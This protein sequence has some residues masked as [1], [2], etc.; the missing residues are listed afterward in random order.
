MQKLAKHKNA[1]KEC[2]EY[3][4][5]RKE[6]ME[7]EKTEVARANYKYDLSIVAE[8]K[9]H[10]AELWSIE[11]RAQCQIEDLRDEMFYAALGD[12]MKLAQ[13]SQAVDDDQ[14]TEM[15]ADVEDHQEDDQKTELGGTNSP[16]F[17]DEEGGLPENPNITKRLPT[18]ES[19]RGF[20]AEALRDP[21]GTISWER[22]QNLWPDFT[23]K[24][25]LSSMIQFQRNRDQL[26]S[27]DPADDEQARRG[28]GMILRAAD[29]LR[30][31]E[32]RRVQGPWCPGSV[33]GG[34]SRQSADARASAPTQQGR[35]LLPAQGGF[36]LP[37]PFAMAGG[38]QLPPLGNLRQ[39]HPPGPG[40]PGVFPPR[41]F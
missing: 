17:S 41:P 40:G 2:P 31:S 35:R 14:H 12:W 26:D 25:R 11:H 10:E 8:Q 36:G 30:E 27:R 3:D 7:R 38:P 21:A 32:E 5:V 39:L 20:V 16:E 15:M 37:D 1:H 9:E 28:V 22:G 23:I 24:V 34:R 6:L 18:R 29:H 33:R 4:Q 13:S 19:E